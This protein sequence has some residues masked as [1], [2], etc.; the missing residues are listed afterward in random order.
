[1]KSTFEKHRIC[2]RNSNIPHCCIEYFVN[3]WK[4]LSLKEKE[5][6]RP[7]F[8]E[9]ALKYGYAPCYSCLR[10]GRVAKVKICDI[11][12]YKKCEVKICKIKEKL[13]KNKLI[14]EGIL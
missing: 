10:L 14:K 7:D 5:I 8:Q 9:I 3:E 6:R 4:P 12:D 2:G 13:L 11:K 1:M